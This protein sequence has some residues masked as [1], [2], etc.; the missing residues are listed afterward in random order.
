M[1]KE[2]FTFQ[3]EVSKLLDIV[4]RSLYSH[5]EVFLRELI[6]NASDACDRLRYEALTSPDLI[7]SDG[8][9]KIS[10]EADEKKGTLT[11][12]DN[13]I[14]MSRQELVETL[15]TIAR[16]GTQ[17]FMDKLSGDAAKDV[18]LIGQF[19][20]GFYSSFMVADMVEVVTLKAGETQGW[21]WTSDGRGAFT[22]EEAQRSGR[23]TSVIVHL[24]ADSK[25][26][27]D[28]ARLESVVKRYSDH[29]AIPIVL[30]DEKDGKSINQASA[31]WARPRAEVTDAQYNEFYHHVS[32]DFDDPWLT[33]H[34]K[35]EGVVS[36]SNLLFIPKT[37]PFDLFEPERKPKLKLYVRR[38]FITDDCAELLPGYLRFVR[39]VVDSEDLSLNL[40]REM[41][42]RDPKLRKIRG[43]LVKRV[44]G[45]LAKKAEAAAEEYAAFWG[46]FG[47]VLKEGIY[48]DMENRN[49]L[50][51][52]A[53]FRTTAGT[54][55]VTLD[56][57]VGRMK[58]GQKAIYYITGE[59]VNAIGNS[60]QLEG[61]KARGVEVLLLTDPVDEFWVPAVGIYKEKAFCSVTRA[62]TDLS[63]VEGGE[64]EAA[65]KDGEKPEARNLD[66]LVANFKLALGK[67]VSDVRLSKRLTESPVCLV[68]REG[69]MDMR[70]ERILKRHNQ[71]GEGM[72][73]PGPILEVNPDHALIGKL[74]A[75]AD[76]GATF[77]ESVSEMAHLLLD[78]A[79]ILE[80]EAVP[81]P[82]AFARR[83]NLMLEKGLAG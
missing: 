9:F 46:T 34:N 66:A 65:K 27:L 26:F 18:S 49:A 19:G 13:G 82:I 47:P 70:L 11:I 37:Q 1:G 10:L 50:L 57:Y 48:E 44:L 22:V 38:V 55:R 76:Q 79:R 39:G 3:A 24:T 75:M 5:K 20:V 30:V 69:G 71:L 74:G 51:E 32:H 31:L 12:A 35:V 23:G 28:K 63:G 2:S 80:G 78:Q 4:A 53:R 68:A 83:L 56:T 45:D 17:A 14:G 72:E 21:R 64:S 62:D 59:D 81:D 61:F 42:Q 15:G 6:S 41:L 7:G 29:I 25:E 73:G 33:I 52:L 77:A 60:P 43:G 54:E 58:N 8:A 40:S 16:S 36:Y 67:S